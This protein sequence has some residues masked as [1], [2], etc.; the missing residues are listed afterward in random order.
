[1]RFKYRDRFPN[2]P[3]TP[4][5]NV[6]QSFGF[7][8]QNIQFLKSWRTPTPEETIAQCWL[9][10]NSGATGVVFSDVQID[11]TNHGFMT[12]HINDPDWYNR[13]EYGRWRGF[14]PDTDPNKYI[15]SMVAGP[16][17]PPGNCR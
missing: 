1:M 13:L 10:L 12:G 2:L 9:S 6:V 8:D 16:A 4:V 15:D 17:E 3:V 14:T 7:I 5:W 11:G